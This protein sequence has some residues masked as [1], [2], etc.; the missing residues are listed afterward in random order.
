MPAQPTML[1]V[2]SSSANTAQ[3]I[4]RFIRPLLLIALITVSLPIEA[5]QQRPNIVFIFTDDHAP[6]AIGA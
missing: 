4:L 1:E 6:N 2:D 5:N 3:R